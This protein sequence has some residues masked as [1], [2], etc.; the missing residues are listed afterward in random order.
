MAILTGPERRRR[1]SEAERLRIVE[2][3]CAPGARVADVAR[4]HEVSRGLIYT[5]RR[6]FRR[7]SAPVFVPAIVTDDVPASGAM[8]EASIVLELPDGRRLRIA[9]SA[10][11][12]LVV[13]AL[14]AVR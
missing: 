6:E 3:A 5:W 10:P 8:A 1:W 11:P 14:R 13:A 12:A 2:E 4:R 7:L 9:A